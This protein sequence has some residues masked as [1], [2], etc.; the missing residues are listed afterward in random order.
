M[1]PDKITKGQ[2]KGQDYE[3]Q[4]CEVLLFFK[5]PRVC[6]LFGYKPWTPKCKYIFGKNISSELLL[7][8]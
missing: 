5:P 7:V 2:D 6:L 1:V 4:P 3:N 8:T